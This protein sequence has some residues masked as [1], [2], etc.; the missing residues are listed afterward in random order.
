MQLLAI[1][2]I[3]HPEIYQTYALSL[4]QQLKLNN[5]LH[6]TKQKVRKIAR[7]SNVNSTDKSESFVDSVPSELINARDEIKMNVLLHRWLKQAFKDRDL[8]GESHVNYDQLIDSLKNGTDTFINDGLFRPTGFDLHYSKRNRKQRGV[9]S[10]SNATLKVLSKI[11]SKFGDVK[12]ISI[13]AINSVIYTRLI[14]DYITTMMRVFTVVYIPITSGIVLMTPSLSNWFYNNYILRSVDDI[15]SLKNRRE[16]T[17]V[18]DRIQYDTLVYDETPKSVR[19]AL[20]LP[21]IILLSERGKSF[22]IGHNFRIRTFAPLEPERLLGRTFYEARDFLFRY[23]VT[24]SISKIYSLTDKITS[25]SSAPAPWGNRLTQNILQ[26]VI[27]E[28]KETGVKRIINLIANKGTGKTTFSTIIKEQF[29]KLLMCD[30]SKIIVVDSD[31]FGLYLSDELMIGA[32]DVKE[33]I[34]RTDDKT[35]LIEIVARMFLNDKM[36][37]NSAQYTRASIN[38]RTLLL[39]QFKQLLMALWNG[40]S[41][42]GYIAKKL[43]SQSE[44]YDKI[45]A[46]FPDALLMVFML[47]TTPEQANAARD[48]LT[49]NLNTI[50]NGYLSTHSRVDYVEIFLYDLYSEMQNSS[51]APLCPVDLHMLTQVW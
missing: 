34:T 32:A 21:N 19:M 47:H 26:K 51:H 41:L 30:E 14:P 35:S 23:G 8:D 13:H 24:D 37:K 29:S 18:V 40:H 12:S 9:H 48:S 46:S 11:R 44:F 1:N 38:H 17:M 7:M 36:I 4:R 3:D 42:P 43:T 6:Q 31:A 45:S 33:V 28:I 22:T 5:H 10:I 2:P 16:V 27:E 39:G 25:F 15:K 49:F 20:Q 50:Y